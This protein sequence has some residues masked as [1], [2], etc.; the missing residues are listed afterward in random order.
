MMPYNMHALLRRML[1]SIC[2]NRRYTAT[3]VSCGSHASHQD[4]SIYGLGKLELRK[5][6]PMIK[7]TRDSV[8]SVQVPV[9]VSHYCKYQWFLGLIATR[10]TQITHHIIYYC[11]CTLRID[12]IIRRCMLCCGPLLRS[13]PR[14]RTTRGM[15]T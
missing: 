4:C 3:T 12:I 6:L 1:A 5:K 13:H 11:Y 14:E 8:Q 15:K 9:Q 2:L 10:C 7:T